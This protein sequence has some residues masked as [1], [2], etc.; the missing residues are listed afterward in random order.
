MQLLH[1]LTINFSSSFTSSCQKRLENTKLFLDTVDLVLLLE[2]LTLSEVS[3][4]KMLKTK[5]RK[6][7]QVQSLHVNLHV[8]EIRSNKLSLSQF[9]IKNS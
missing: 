7:K 5:K 1:Q 3:E 2:Q 6:S 8:K 9:E 4:D